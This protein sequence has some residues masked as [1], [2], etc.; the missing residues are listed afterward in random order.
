MWPGTRLLILGFDLV[1]NQALVTDDA[2]VKRRVGVLRLHGYCYQQCHRLLPGAE[3]TWQCSTWLNTSSSRRTLPSYTVNTSRMV[4]STASPSSLFQLI[5]L[6]RLFFL[7]FK[8]ISLEADHGHCLLPHHDAYLQ[9]EHFHF[10][11]HNRHV[12]TG[13]QWSALPEP[14]LLQAKHNQHLQPPLTW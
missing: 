5:P 9:R 10:L 7:I 6:Q 14:Y 3:S 8:G 1:L 2:V 13:R 4:N 12:C 11:L